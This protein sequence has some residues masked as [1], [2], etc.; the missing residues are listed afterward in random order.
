MTL[1]AFLAMLLLADHEL[2]GCAAT[3]LT[4]QAD[5]VASLPSGHGAPAM[6]DITLI[7]AAG[8]PTR[9]NV[10]TGKP[11]FIEIQCRQVAWIVVL[12]NRLFLAGSLEVHLMDAFCQTIEAATTKVHVVTVRVGLR[13][14]PC[15]AHRGFDEI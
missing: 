14:L 15:K 4:I 7:V 1:F 13:P 9:I 11:G 6:L 10:C 8:L 2:A 3:N 12:E 5:I